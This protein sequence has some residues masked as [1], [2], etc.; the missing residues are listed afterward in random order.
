MI[1]FEDP[2]ERV[3][4]FAAERY[5]ISAIVRFVHPN[6]FRSR[7][8]PFG[9]RRPKGETFW[10]DDGGVPE[11]SID[12]TLRRGVSGTLDILA[13]ELAHVIAGAEVEHGPAWRS[14]Y[15]SLFE[16]ACLQSFVARKIG[17][18]K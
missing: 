14:A 18:G 1:E 10:P 4:A 12:A 11:I 16:A 17:P 7:F 8:D 5:G 2:F 15:K 9:L 13:H 6:E 3:M